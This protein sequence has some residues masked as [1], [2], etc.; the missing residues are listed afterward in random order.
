MKT[1]L[2]ILLFVVMATA[3]INADVYVRVKSHID[4]YYYGDRPYPEENEEWEVWIGGNRFVYVF[5]LV[6]I[7]TYGANTVP[8]CPKVPTPIPLLQLL[9]HVKYLDRPLPLQKTHH[10]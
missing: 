6:L 3:Y 7:Q 2:S 9:A 4:S 5:D 8:F 1:C 10:L